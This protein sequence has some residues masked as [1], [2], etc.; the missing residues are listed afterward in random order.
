MEPEGEVEV[1]AYAEVIEG[2][3]VV[4]I[5]VDQGIEL[6]TQAGKNSVVKQMKLKK[7]PVPE[8]E[9]QQDHLDLK[10]FPGHLT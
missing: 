10:A 9:H 1:E 4:V 6:G 8:E 5:F 7:Q 3:S 2:A